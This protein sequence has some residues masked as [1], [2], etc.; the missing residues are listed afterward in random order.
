MLHQKKLTELKGGILL[1]NMEC[2]L[3]ISRFEEAD[4]K[5]SSLREQLKQ[6]EGLRTCLTALLH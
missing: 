1:G 2:L 4:V 6:S 3:K 5:L